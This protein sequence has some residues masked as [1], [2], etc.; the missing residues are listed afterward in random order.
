MGEADLDVWRFIAPQSNVFSAQPEFD[1]GGGKG[2]VQLSLEWSGGTSPDSPV[3]SVKSSKGRFGTASKRM[4]FHRE[5]PPSIP[6]K[7]TS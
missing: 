2:T 3:P 1:L 4:S 6:T 7:S 5:A